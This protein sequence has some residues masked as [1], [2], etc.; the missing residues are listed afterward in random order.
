MSALRSQSLERVLTRDQ[1]PLKIDELKQALSLHHEIEGDQLLFE[2]AEK[3][4]ELI[5]GSLVT[6]RQGTLQVI[7]LTVKEFLTSTHRP[8][9]STYSDLL[10]DPAKANLALTLA[11]LK[12]IQSHCNE[13][14]VSLDPKIA[15]LDRKLDVEAVVE[16]QRQA[17]L[18]EYAS[19]T[20]MVHLTECDGS[21]MI[22]VSK[23]FQ[24]TFDSPSTF[25]WVEACMAF[26]PDSVLHLIAGLEEVNEYISG[27]GPDQWQESEASCVFIADWCHA[28]RNTFEEYGTIL[29]RRPWEVHLLDLQSSFSVNKQFYE[30]FSV[31]SR[32][33]TTLRITGYK[34]PRSCRPEPQ[35]HSRLQDLQGGLWFESIIF[36]IHDERRAL[37]FW[38]ERLTD[39]SSVRLFVQNATTGQRLAPAVNLDGGARREGSLY[40]YGLS[41]S[42]EFIVVVY[43]I[44]TMNAIS[45]EEYLTLIWQVNEGMRFKKRMRSE[46][47]ARIVFSH[48][49]GSALEDSIMNVTFPDRDHCLTPSGKIHLASGSRRPLLDPL[50][51]RHDTNERR[52]RGIFYCQ[53]GKYCFISEKAYD[54]VS[55]IRRAVRVELCTEMSERLCSWKE[56]SRHLVDVSPSG[57]FLV[58]SI[59]QVGRG[60]GEAFLCLYDVDTSETIQLPFVER[61][62]YLVA[63][64]QF[65]KDEMELIVFISCRIRGVSTMNVLVWGDLQ[66]DPVLRTYGKLNLDHEISPSH[67]HVNSDASSALLVLEKRII[68]RVEFG[69]RVEFPG[70]PDVD[71]DY[72]RILT[73][74]SR[75]GVRTALLEYGKEKA[76]LQVTELSSEKGLI[77]RLDLQLSPCDEPDSRVVRFSP[78]L[79][80]LVVDAQIFPI[81][82]GL[83]GL[84]STSFTT[85]GLSELLMRHRARLQRFHYCQLHCLISP[86]NSYIM[87]ISPGDPDAREAN[88]PTLYAFRLDL[89]SRSSAR[90]DLQLP[91]D[92][93]FISADL[94]PSQPL[95]LLTY[96]TF[97]K[98]DVRVLGESPLL[99]VCIVEFESLEMKPVVLPKSRSFMQRMNK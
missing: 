48:Q 12:C 68:Q 90:L 43:S 83:H 40:S 10:I 3:D 13:S 8:R 38:G 77:H 97:A 93:G 21:Q 20:W 73:Q 63:K 86:C 81:A 76:R 69:T 95:M 71:Y 23:A 15:R 16:R 94:H 39:L 4:I 7:H 11:C 60:K 6:V 70:A 54:G 98:P 57:R 56:S 37:Y 62:D 18:A 32:R 64:Y 55:W 53:N 75:D 61:L 87:F 42:G 44:M 36:F 14:F 31:T 92:L 24:K 58:L 33:D 78:N 41:P 89:A 45:K 82:E 35:A 79:N 46:S 91:K 85:P 96:S 65:A 5:C 17:P 80:L 52:T 59:D 51:N 1:R 67:I 19:F 88:P 66:T 84:S 2:Y 26:N 49:C 30:K 25:H 72:P 74:A 29:S 22:G 47:W 34:S 27:L 9:H 99:Q 28:L 50:P